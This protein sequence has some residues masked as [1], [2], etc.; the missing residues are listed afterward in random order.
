MSEL[1]ASPGPPELPG[2]LVLAS[3]SPRR[4]E[5]LPLIGIPFEIVEPGVT[6][7]SGGEPAEVVVENARRKARA[8][9]RLAGP[10][11]VVIGCDT[12]V[13][14]DGR[15]LGKPGDAGAAR[16]RLAMLSGRDHEVLSGVAVAW[17][18]GC[19]TALERTAVGFASLS[20][21]EIDAYLAS[22]EWEGRAGGYAV[23]GL[24]SSLVRRIDGDLSS[25]IGLPLGAVRTLLEG[26]QNG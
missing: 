6:E 24:G 22:G 11:A 8:G 2:R 17:K 21:V 25:V 20:R 4:R 10:D 13:V 9:N 26:L 15:V 3:A 18:E 23:Q 12:D 5:L 1:V 14:C 16:E 19:S 7:I